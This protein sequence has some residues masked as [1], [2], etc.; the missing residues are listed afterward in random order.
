MM[1]MFTQA[2]IFHT[3]QNITNAYSI[4]VAGRNLLLLY[5]KTITYIVRNS[6]LSGPL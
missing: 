6:T 3:L 2:G 5:G 4:E 1:I